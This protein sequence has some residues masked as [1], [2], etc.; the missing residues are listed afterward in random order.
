V[1]GERDATAPPD[2][3]AAGLAYERV[4]DDGATATYVARRDG[5]VVGVLHVVDDP[6]RPRFER[7]PPPR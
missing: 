5:T 6:A 3:P 2:V 4:A 7:T 1:T